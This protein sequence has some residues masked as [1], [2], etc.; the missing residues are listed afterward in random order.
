VEPDRPTG[1]H[2]LDEMRRALEDHN[3]D[4]DPE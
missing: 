1:E 3:L 4:L 2:P